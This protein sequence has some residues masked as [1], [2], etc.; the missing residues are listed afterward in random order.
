MSMIWGITPICI[1]KFDDARRLITASEDLLVQ[2]KMIRKDDVVVIVIGLA[3]TTGS[4]NL[5]KIHRVG[6]DD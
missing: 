5:I 3:F 4:T 1:P 6:R 2:K